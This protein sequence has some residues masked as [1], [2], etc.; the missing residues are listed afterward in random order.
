MGVGGNVG[1]CGGD[2]GRE[3]GKTDMDKPTPITTGDAANYKNNN[4]KT[5]LFHNFTICAYGR[6]ITV[7]H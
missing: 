1:V 4:Y 6:V 5:H 3:M 2:W 7:V